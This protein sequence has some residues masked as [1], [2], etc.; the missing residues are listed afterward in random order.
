MNNVYILI[1]VLII[2]TLG[3]LFSVPFLTTYMYNRI[4]DARRG[5]YEEKTI[6][7][8]NHCEIINEFFNKLNYVIW[9]LTA[10]IVLT[11]QFEI[12]KNIETIN[13]YRV[14]GMFVLIVTIYAFYHITRNDLLNEASSSVI[15]FDNHYRI[16]CVCGCFL[17]IFE[18]FFLMIIFIH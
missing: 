4:V 11:Y 2:L 10:V 6:M 16:P 7:F 17:A 14:S 9:L 12:V 15:V 5:D 3:V 18:F 13:G 8:S 1:Q